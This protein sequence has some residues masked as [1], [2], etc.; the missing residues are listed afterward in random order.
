MATTYAFQK[1]KYGGQ[2]GMIFPYFSDLPSNNP[3][4]AEYS[5]NIPAGFLRC[6]GQILSADTYPQLAAVLGVGNAC[7]YKKSDVV[8]NDP[9]EDGTGGT[10]QLP[11]LGSKYIS[12]GTTPGSYNDLTVETA[13]TATVTYRAGVEVSL[14]ALNTD[15]QFTYTGNFSIPQH[16]VN[17]SGQW[18]VRSNTSTGESSVNEGQIL[19]HGH[20][21]TFAQ[22][23]DGRSGQCGGQWKWV[24]IYYYCN[25]DPNIVQ[26]NVGLMRLVPIG[27]GAAEAGS[28]TGTNHKHSNANFVIPDGIS[29][30]GVVAPTGTTNP[31]QTRT[32][33]MA[34][35]S[36]SAAS[37]ITTVKLNTSTTTK[38]DAVSPK[39]VICEYLIKI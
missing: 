8:L 5:N 32:G 4:E 33:I 2:T 18:T 19:T 3:L 13:T 15:V 6:R 26:N 34:A 16:N 36:F 27:I 24:A 31:G 22:L 7:I 17:I 37:I 10:F 21:A 30:N 12:A 39:F 1:G 28:E 20:Y 38:I 14:T 23:T 35:T 25:K 29:T 11:D 9:D